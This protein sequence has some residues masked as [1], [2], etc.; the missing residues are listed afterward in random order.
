MAINKLGAGGVLETGG[1]PTPFSNLFTVRT[2]ETGD[3]IEYKV[4]GPDSTE[5]KAEIAVGASE[6]TLRFTEFHFGTTGESRQKS[7]LMF[8]G[9]VIMAEERG[10]KYVEIPTGDKSLEHL[11]YVPRIGELLG[12]DAVAQGRKLFERDAAPQRR[13]TDQTQQPIRI[14][15]EHFTEQLKEY[16]RSHGLIA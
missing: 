14:S 10:I 11:F 16:E 7:L 8:K 12:E 4:K 5:L 6:P 15:L 2:I 1:E 13:A 3:K 9:L